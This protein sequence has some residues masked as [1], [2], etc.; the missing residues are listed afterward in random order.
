MDIIEKVWGRELIVADELEYCGKILVLRKG[1]GSSI[2]MHPKKKETLF[3]YKGRVL[4]ALADQPPLVLH[5]EAEPVI[6]LPG[7]WHQFYGLED[8]EIMETST[9]HDD[10]DVER[11][12]QSYGSEDY[13]RN[14][15]WRLIEEEL[16]HDPSGN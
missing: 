16:S 8:S 3:C 7:Q 6:V 15:Y 5:R 2:H 13:Y 14:Q 4:F 9:H 10:S 11:R 1:A 12:T